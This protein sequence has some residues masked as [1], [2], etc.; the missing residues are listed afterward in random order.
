MNIIFFLLILCFWG[1]SWIAIAWQA[2][3]VPSLVSIFYRFAF[4]G[5]IFMAALLACRRLQPSSLNDHA[6]F[7]LQGLLLFCLNFIG[8]YLATLY[9]ASGLVALV[10]SSTIVLNGVNSYFFYSHTL[11]RRSIIA[12]AFGLCGLGLVFLKDISI[13][14]DFD[15]IKGILL[16]M[17][18]TCSFSLGNMVTVRNNMKN[19]DLATS[20]A[21]AMCYGSLATL[22]LIKIMGFSLVWDSSVRYIGA[23]IFLVLG[24]S[25]G[26]FTLYLRLVTKVGPTKAAYVLIVTPMIAII[27]SS[28]FEGYQWHMNT[29]Y[30]F[31]LVMAGN[32]MV[33]RGDRT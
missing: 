1:I 19:I 4:A 30:G 7:I 16:A 17:L 32:I 22:G 21:W 23:L 33:L 29:F 15:M 20:T 3:D 28:I 18:G 31:C 14:Y 9:I 13:S 27:I 25:I 5:V 10:M 12:A 26:G 11:S 2:G 8:F 24:A 6:F